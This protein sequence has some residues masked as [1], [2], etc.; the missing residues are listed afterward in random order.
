[1]QVI[2]PGFALER[3]EYG[4]LLQLVRLVL[5]VAALSWRG[6]PRGRLAR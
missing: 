1:L 6:G 3:R 2:L 4:L 5:I